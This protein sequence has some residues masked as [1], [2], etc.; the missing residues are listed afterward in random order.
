MLTNEVAEL[1]TPTGKG[2][3]LI[4]TV[5]N[6][7]RSDDGV[8]PFIAEQVF[9][10][11]DGINILNAGNTPENIVWEAAEIGAVR[12]VFLD[13]ADFNGTPG[14][15]RIIDADSIPEKTFSTHRFPLRVI[16]N[17][18]REDTGAEVFFIG[19]Q[20]E[21]LEFGEGLSAPVTATASE[22]IRHLSSS[23]CF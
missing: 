23:F 18:L 20:P 4:I 6:S 3:L 21:R 16:A 8:G 11:R 7:F 22:I 2:D 13:A 17:I 9:S 10:P 5:G 14:E 1:L 19:I 15:P 12:V